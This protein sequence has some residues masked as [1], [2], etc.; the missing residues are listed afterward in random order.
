MNPFTLGAIVFA[1][2]FGAALLAMRVRAAL[3]QHHLR[4]DTQDTVKLAMG[5][6]AT[7]AALV[8]GLLVAS[9]K[10]GYDT[11]K[12]AVVQMAAKV[13]F[14]DRILGHYGPDTAEARALLRR[15]FESAVTHMWPESRFQQAELAPN[16]AS[17]V[18]LYDALQRLAPQNESQ[19]TLKAQALGL[20]LELGQMRWLLFEQSGTSIATPLLVIVVFWLAILFFSFGLFGPSNATALTA[21][22]VASLSV[23][24]A[25]FLILELD[26]PFGGLI[27]IS[28]QPML[29]ALQQLGQ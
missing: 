2:V 18:A 25:I 28:D 6:V 17:G 16:A 12:T 22:L 3:P 27:R 9:A 20:G 11:Q 1:C 24:G 8:L 15:A 21:L 26:R 5:L 19:R 13:A 14:L 4:P 7:M 10:G 23:S 29:N